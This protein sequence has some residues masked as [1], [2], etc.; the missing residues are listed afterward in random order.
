[1]KSAER[2][3]K[4]KHEIGV[5]MALGAARGP[6]LRLMLSE[7]LELTGIGVIVGLG[8]SL[9]LDE[10]ISSLLHGVGTSD[11]AVLGSVSLLLVGVAVAACHIPA[12]RASNVDP[13]PALREWVKEGLPS[14]YFFFLK[15]SLT[16]LT[17]S[18]VTRSFSAL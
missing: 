6:V 4:Q 2:V 13:M 3:A 7:G 15:A 18:L 10:S 9:A 17:S 1:M 5:R 16:F 8:S 14:V 12:I 11:L